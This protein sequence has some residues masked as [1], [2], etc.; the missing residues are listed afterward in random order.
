MK[1]KILEKEKDSVRFEVDGIP[2]ELANAL[3]RIMIAEVPTLAI[4]EVYFTENNSAMFDEIIAHRM[5][6][7]PLVFP[8]DTFEFQENCDCGGEGCTNCQVVITLE[9]EGPCTVYTGDLKSSAKE[10]TPLFDNM[11]IVKLEKGQKISLEAIATL[12]KGKDHIKHK[13]AIASYKY[14][15]SVKVDGRKCENCG[16]CIDVCPKGI[17]K[18]G[19]TKPKVKNQK[20]CI[21]CNACLEA[22][23]EGA[24]EVKGEENKFI[25]KVESCS[26]LKPQEIVTKACNIL[27][28]KGKELKKE[29]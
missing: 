14:Y 6:L 3:R 20:K 18:K 10:V 9:K 2:V 12:G 25:F 16:D 26:G 4:K 28:N 8:Q 17:L 13:S 22:C 23:D 1:I 21:L 5:G 27:E 29:L 11:P 19:K 7:I 24:I 15:P